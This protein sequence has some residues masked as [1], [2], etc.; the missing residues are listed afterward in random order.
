MVKRPPRHTRYWTWLI[1]RN[2]FTEAT[3]YKLNCLEQQ[4]NGMFPLCDTPQITTSATP[5]FQRGTFR[6]YSIKIHS[7]T[8]C[9]RALV[10]QYSVTETAPDTRKAGKREGLVAD[11][12]TARTLCLEK[13]SNTFSHDFN[14]FGI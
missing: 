8:I 3:F 11:T 1:T 14:N 12:P 13:S 2:T 6:M 4:T 10:H 9:R 5:A 7:M